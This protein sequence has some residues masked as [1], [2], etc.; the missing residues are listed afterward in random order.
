MGAHEVKI[1]IDDIL[2]E[3]AAYADEIVEA[4]AKEALKETRKYARTAFKDKTGLLRAKIG[5]KRSKYDR[6]TQIVGAFA[7]HAHLVEFG[8]AML[9][10]D[11]TPT[12]VDAWFGEVDHVPAHPFLSKASR[13]IQA[14]WREIA[15]SV[16][17]PTTE[18]KRR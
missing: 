16:V 13:A 6:N 5:R 12:K 8:H 15:E 1:P 18:V 17:A 2:R 14:R 3:Y 7:P 4:V 10:H 11:G 9:K